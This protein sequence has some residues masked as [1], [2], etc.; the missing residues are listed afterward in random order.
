MRIQTL[1]LFALLSPAAPA[2]A[3]APAH[4]G[5]SHSPEATLDPAG[6]FDLDFDMNGQATK[7]ILR[8]TREGNGSLKGT[9]D[10]HGQSMRLET[11]S[12]VNRVVRVGNSDLTLT[13]DFTTDNAFTGKWASPD[14]GGTL[15]G[16]RRK[17]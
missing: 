7:A 11:V 10:V 3:Q 8:V 14:G 9:L 2:L 13:L 4:S 17:P 1:L 6:T 5:S 12:T 16:T 15:T